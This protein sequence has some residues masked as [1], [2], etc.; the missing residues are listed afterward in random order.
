MDFKIAG[1]FESDSELLTSDLI[2]ISLKDFKGLFGIPE[3]YGHR[4]CGRCEQRNRGAYDRDE[5]AGNVP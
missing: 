5:G 4:P 2:V 1:V 3:G